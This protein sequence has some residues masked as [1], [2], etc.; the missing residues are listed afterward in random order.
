MINFDIKSKA[1]AID[2][3][4]QHAQNVWLHFVAI[5]LCFIGILGLFYGVKFALYIREDIQ[6]NLAHIVGM[7]WLLYYFAANKGWG[8]VMLVW[9]II[10]FWIQY[11]FEENGFNLLTINILIITL[12]LIAMYIGHKKENN[13]NALKRDITAII[14]SPAWHIQKIFQLL[15]LDQ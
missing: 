3:D 12:A 8:L 10:T 13:I 5:P 4:H 15:E 1:V 6:L 11:N 7:V 14:Y 2:Q 9:L